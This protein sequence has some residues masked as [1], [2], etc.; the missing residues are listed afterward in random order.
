M[1]T[2]EKDTARLLYTRLRRFTLAD[3]QGR[4]ARIADF[5]IDLAGYDYPPITHIL[6]R[7]GTPALEVLPWEA[8]VSLDRDA[9]RIEV[10]DIE[11]SELAPREWQRKRVLLGDVDDAMVLD[12]E[13]RRAARANGLILKE[14]GGRVFL[15]GVDTS[16]TAILRKATGGRF[17]YVPEAAVHDWSRVEF[18]RGDPQAVRNEAKDAGRIAELPAGEI[19]RMTAQLP[20]LHAAEMVA[21]LPD[22]L[23]I[24][25]FEAMPP[26]RQLQ[27][28]EELD[29]VRA[30]RLLE[31][32]APDVAAD[33]LGYLDT[34]TIMSY[35]RR[36][37]KAQRERI[38]EL[39]RYPEDTVGGIMT[40]DILFAPEGWTIAETRD[41]LRER[42]REPDFVYLIFVVD[43]EISR[44]PTGVIPLRDLLTCEDGQTLSEVM[45]TKVP[46][47][48]VTDPA[49]KG[50]YQV[51]DSQLAALP[52]AGAEGHIAGAVTV[53]AAV[54]QVAP[55]AW[56]S[57]APRI[58]S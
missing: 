31:I 21:L 30:L 15:S 12:L 17:A 23:A 32:M 33:L 27:I 11:A 16:L 28:F 56:R 44:R 49:R 29:E 36:L 1:T 18:L 4:R 43:D 24:N 5:V 26:R 58:F 51:I 38:I 13:H 25:T 42:L 20:Y 14:E 34:G 7:H 47:L 9:R 19:A 52:V 54:V 41:R 50:A 46:V 37:P 39:L 40:N 6:F 35:L 57:Q 53:D 48:K 55:H 8:V 3:P 2:S 22:A 10:R 45:D